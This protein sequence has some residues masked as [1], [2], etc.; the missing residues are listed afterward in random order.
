MKL[1]LCVMRD[2]MSLIGDSDTMPVLHLFA[3]HSKLPIA[4]LFSLYLSSP[5]YSTAPDA[6]RRLNVCG[7]SAPWFIPEEDLGTSWRGRTV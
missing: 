5:T 7:A 3:V 1:C 2:S 4:S 6:H